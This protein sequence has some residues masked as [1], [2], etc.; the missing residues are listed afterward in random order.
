MTGASLAASALQ[1]DWNAAIT[2]DSRRGWFVGLAVVLV[3]NA[4]IAAAY[5]LRVISAMY[6]KT[7]KRGVQADGGIAAGLAMLA[8]L[9]LVAAVTVQPRRLFMAAS[10]AGDAVSGML[11]VAVADAR[12]AIP[13][14]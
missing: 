7:T 4:A 13:A 6:F 5:Y 12:S 3:L 2:L 9:V 11:P 10:R 8:C 1:V 14:R